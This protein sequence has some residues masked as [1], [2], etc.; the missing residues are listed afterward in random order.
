MD[1]RQHPTDTI[2][3]RQH[4]K[5]CRR[6]G[7]CSLT[8]I[9][10]L[11]LKVFHETG[12]LCQPHPVIRLDQLNQLII[13]A[14]AH[15]LVSIGTE[16]FEL[17]PITPILTLRCRVIVGCKVGESVWIFAPNKLFEGYFRRQTPQYIP[18]MQE[19]SSAYLQSLEH[20]LVGEGQIVWGSR[21]GREDEH[22]GFSYGGF[23][24]V[25]SL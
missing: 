17:I 6:L 12:H 14:K 8:R 15:L 19:I 18:Q 20:R 16:Y 11:L 9:I 21:F 2:L 24:H 25:N 4:F 1:S 13:I 5:E 7:C 22:G 3:L 23:L 10:R